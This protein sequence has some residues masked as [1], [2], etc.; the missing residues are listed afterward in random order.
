MIDELERTGKTSTAGRISD[1][2]LPLMKEFVVEAT[3]HVE[4]AEASILKLEENPQ[5][6]EAIDA[7]FRSFHSIKGVAGFLHLEQLG[8][9][10]H[11]AETMIN[12]VRQGNGAW[13]GLTVDLV[14]DSVD[15]MKHMIVA[16]DES[17]RLDLPLAF[18]ARLPALL[19]RLGD[20]V[21]GQLNAGRG[22]TVEAG[23]DRAVAT[24]SI[25]GPSRRSS[26]AT[27]DRTVKVSTDRLDALINLVGEL[28]IAQSMT[29]QG[30]TA[31]LDA[32]AKQIRSISQLGKIAG[33]LQELSMSMRMVP[34]HGMFQKMARL[35]RDLAHQVGKE[36][37]FS[38]IGG[39]TEIDRNLV[40]ALSDPLVHMVRNAVDHGI[41]PPDVRAKAGKPRCG[42]LEL[43]AY[44]RGGCIVVEV[45]DDGLGLNQQRILAKA[46]QAGIVREDQELSRQDVLQLIFHP[47]LSTAEQVT[48]V[49]GRGVGMDVVRKNVETL[50]GRIDIASHEGRGSTF[51]LRLPLTLAVIDGLVAKVGSERYIIPIASV[52]Q[53]LR[54]TADQLSQVHGRGELCR[55]RDGV[56]PLFRLH[57]LFG[58]IPTYDE[59]AEAIVVVVQDGDHRCCLMV[60]ELLGQQ[61]VV[62]K[63][64]GESLAM[65]PGVSGGG[66]LGDGN[67]SL[68]VD[69]PGLIGLAKGA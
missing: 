40:E 25:T 61:Q 9:L 7:I 52:E 64:L 42:R 37:E 33:E 44:H 34:V 31:V 10:A 56:L 3:G 16:L 45:S 39:E 63:S 38:A 17:V 15:S 43:K 19:Q 1:E 47:G 49:S 48:D 35:V 12:Q 62:I 2:D 4:T 28:V 11:A 24:A 60:D 23:G 20:W 69:V 8:E 6:T 57:K 46:V 65:V 21:P 67:V 55:I 18:E 29:S 41:E 26:G 5:D 30:L 22:A 68:I 13:S 54:P 51:T 50:R 36:I 27:S 53:S 66:I 59:P 58:V 32:D 14:L